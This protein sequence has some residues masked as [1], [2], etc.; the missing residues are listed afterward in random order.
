MDILIK[1]GQLILSLSLLVLIHEFGHFIF[2]KIFKT[3]VEKFYLFFNPWFSLFKVKKGDTE[4]GIGW[5]PLGGYCKISGMI[6]ESMDKEQLSKPPQPWEF[7]SKPSYQRLLIML[8]GVVFNFVAAFFIYS[9]ILFT[10][11]DKYLP[12]ENV[13]YGI[14]CDTL[15]TD[16][17][18]RD[19]DIIHS[20]G[21]KKVEDFRKILPE[22]IYTKNKTVQVSR[23]GQSLDIQLPVD[24]ISQFIER[25]RQFES[26][27]GEDYDFISFG[28]PFYIGSFNPGSAGEKAG[29]RIDDKIIGFNN[30]EI[31]HF[32]QF[33][34]KML[35]YE[36]ETLLVTVDRNGELIDFSVSLDESRQIG[37]YWYK[38]DPNTEL[39]KLFIL[40]EVEYSFFA[41]FPAGLKRG[42]ETI[43]SY[44]K[45]LRLIF[46]PKTKAYKSLGGF[47]AIG[48]IFPSSWDW[49]R[50]WSMTALISIMLAVLNLLP[51]PALDGGHVI[52]LVFEI[53]TGKKPA[54]KFLEYAQIVG[55][56]LLLALVIFA[57]GNDILK[58]FR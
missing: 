3:K 38:N 11:G 41:S 20:V 4:F 24:F 40:K 34:N 30:E 10:W 8:G 7:R 6:D 54:D 58:L 47:I 37:A 26:E 35:T 25:K 22:M 46:T 42:K 1:A 33:R 5:L 36:D 14:S 21:N 55:M 28:I 39:E 15:A 27:Q 52:F 23:N 32:Q 9:M 29:L 43:S 57:N 16:L 45:D 44:L 48:N 31:L 50:F 2:A 13:K 17:G 12:S 49:Y 18:L 19:G 51:I 53:I 56:I